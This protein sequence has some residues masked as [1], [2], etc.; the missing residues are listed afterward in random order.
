ME[1]EIKVIGTGEDEKGAGGLWDLA[2]ELALTA[3]LTIGVKP[4]VYA[5]E[6][7]QEEVYNILQGY[8]TEKSTAEKLLWLVENGLQIYEVRNPETGEIDGSD[9]VFFR[10]NGENIST[11][12]GNREG[13]ISL[14]DGIEITYDWAQAEKAKE[15]EQK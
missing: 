3:G 1:V 7:G 15:S 9:L 11:I 2:G 6:C 10:G 14:E 4:P 5:E 12:V 8:V 13:L